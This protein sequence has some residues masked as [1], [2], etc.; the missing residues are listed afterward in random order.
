MASVLLGVSGGIAAYKAID[1]LRALQRAG[2]DVHVV[3]TH[4]A[5]RFVGASTF[6]ALSGNSVGTT[7]FGDPEHP[8]YRHLTLARTTE[9][10][11]VAPATANTIARMAAGL[12]DDLLTSIYLAYTGPVLVA[13]AMNTRM[14]E[15][16]SMIANLAT[17]V[18][19]GV[20]R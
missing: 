6:A 20:Q 19:R 12:A 17:L 4:G 8:D 2:H 15:H 5:T 18:A 7:L 10:M 3:M 14:W 11:L 1:S 16:P 9:L 13:P